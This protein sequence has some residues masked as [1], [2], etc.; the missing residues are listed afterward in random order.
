MVK[1]CESG[2][3]GRSGVQADVI[4]L[5]RS[6]P[7]IVTAH[8]LK[9]R[10]GDSLDVVVIDLPRPPKGVSKIDMVTFYDDDDNADESDENGTQQ[11]L[12]S[13]SRRFLLMYAKEFKI[14]IPDEVL[15]PLNVPHTHNKVFEHTNGSTVPCN[16]NFHDFEYLTVLE[17]FELN[18][19]QRLIDEH[20][21]N[22]FC[23][24]K[25]PSTSERKQLLYFDRTTMER[26]ICG[27]LLFP[28]SREIMRS[29]VRLV[30][31]VSPRS[32]SVLF[33]LHQCYRNDGCRDYIDGNN[34]K[35]REKL[36][37][38]YR[39]LLSHKLQESVADITLHANSIKNIRTY[40]HEQVILETRDED[41]YVCRLLAMALR[42]DELH[43]ID[44]EPLLL[45]PRH[46]DIVHFMLP[47]RLKK[48]KIRYETDFWK[49]V[50]FS[51]EILSIRG[52]IVWAI[53]RPRISAT[54][55]K[56]R[57][58][59]LVGF[60]KAVKY[61]VHKHDSKAEVIEQLVKLF[62]SDAAHPVNYRESD[63]EDLFVPRCGD[64]VALKKWTEEENVRFVE[65]G[66]LD[67][68]RDGDI[69]GALEAGHSAYLRVSSQLRPQG[70]TYED[71]SA[72]DIRSNVY[73]NFFTRLTSKV[74][75]VSGLSFMA[76]T[77]ALY[78][79]IRLIKSYMNKT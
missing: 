31:G 71:V 43:D 24:S 6:L 60:L 62:G 13:Y 79:G 63:I 65:W 29:I 7:G 52:P 15:N 53:E 78:V 11:N 39:K 47:G 66:T 26:H 30:C 45:S 73:G 27:A 50:G 12:D 22:L 2:E 35:L 49:R 8:K 44:V 75:F 57:L 1:R 33:Y 10:F 61:E 46:A 19:Y 51:G 3:E 48:F 64:Y 42:P 36:L 21:I 76:Y 34:M 28:T 69:S 40:S 9:M 16:N 5:G 59:C 77:A 56:K 17:K 4:V 37:G 68:Y 25:T 23:V 18:Q 54:G 74:N 58:A 32:V 41:T 72:V 67:M 70:A 20:M 14:S 38:Y 55:S